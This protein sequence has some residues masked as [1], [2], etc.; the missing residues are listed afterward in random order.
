MLDEDYNDAKMYKTIHKL[1]NKG[2]LQALKKNIF[3][4]KAP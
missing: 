2:E 4:A 3:V 1:K